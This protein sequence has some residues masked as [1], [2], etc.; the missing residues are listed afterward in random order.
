MI[1]HWVAI[2]YGEGLAITM[3]VVCIKQ[4]ILKFPG[5]VINIINKC[6]YTYFRRFLSLPFSFLCVNDFKQIVQ[7]YEIIKHL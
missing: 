3:K 2:F 5:V 6:E 4:L 7:Y 1:R